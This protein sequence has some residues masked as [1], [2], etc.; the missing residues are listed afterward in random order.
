MPPDVS[1][2]SNETSILT[3]LNN[4]LPTTALHAILAS[5]FV[6]A[7][8]LYLLRKTALSKATEEMHATMCSTEWIYY[9]VVE[10]GIFD[11]GSEDIYRDL[12]Q[13]RVKASLLREQS[14]RA[15]LS[16]LAGILAFC[17]GLSLRIMHCTAEA[18]VLKTRIEIAR[19]E[20]LRRIHTKQT[21]EVY[22]FVAIRAHRSIADIHCSCKL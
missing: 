2:V 15:S 11:Q 3:S 13:L 14:L 17:G 8:L 19:E 4:M 7:L 1:A 18:K 20:G 6:F 16:F 21:S 10:A 9:L 12:E 22:S 5:I